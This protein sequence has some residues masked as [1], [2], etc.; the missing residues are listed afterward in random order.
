[1]LLLLCL[2]CDDCVEFLQSQ[3]NVTALEACADL[4]LYF[5]RDLLVLRTFNG[6]LIPLRNHQD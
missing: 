4:G 5:D 6:H 2:L 3:L 1:M